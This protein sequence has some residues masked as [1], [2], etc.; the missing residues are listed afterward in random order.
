M[1]TFRLGNDGVDT[2]LDT[3]YNKK[4]EL[5]GVVKFP[6]ARNNKL[7]A[8]MHYVASHP[9]LGDPDNESQLRSYMLGFNQA[10]ELLDPCRWEFGDV[11]NIDCNSV[12]P[13]LMYSGDPVSLNGWINT[14]P[15]DQRHI[16]STGPF[17]LVKGKPIE[18]IIAYIVGRGSTSLNSITEARRI[19]N[20][21]IGFY[22]T[23]FTYVSVGV[24]ENIS[25]QLPTEFHLSQNYPNPFNPSTTIKYLI[26]VVDAY[27]ASTTT[28]V[29]LKVYD[30]LGREVATLINK[31]QK[32]GSYE[33]TFDASNLSSGVYFYRL[34]SGGF[35]QSKKM[36]L[37]K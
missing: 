3:A 14:S 19:T 23:N 17:D 28:N 15:D 8:S 1:A 13:S 9:T 24:K 33:V 22:N 12:N 26:P 35:I 29:V 25:T 36:I 31:E 34:K 18:I 10:G 4:G 6:G 5:L 20:D 7:N 2:P 32:A 16:S 37:L 21:V 11:H 30:I 27:Y